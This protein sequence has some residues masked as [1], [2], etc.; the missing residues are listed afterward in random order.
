[1]TDKTPAQV[2]AEGTD[3]TITLTW[4]GLE[5]DIPASAEDL[6][7]DALEALENGKAITF[8]RHLVGSTRYDQV[9]R[10]WQKDHGRKPKPRDMTPFMEE[11]AK[12]YGFDTA[13]N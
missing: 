13:G 8:M 7:L 10:Q 3:D 4:D 5:I 2:E 1:M 6:D 12:T 9:R 11:V